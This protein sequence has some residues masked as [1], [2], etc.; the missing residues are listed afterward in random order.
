MK[1]TTR[2]AE[3][4]EKP[5]SPGPPDRTDNDQQMTSYGLALTPRINMDWISYN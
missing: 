2:K 1:N 3:K 5:R 4:L